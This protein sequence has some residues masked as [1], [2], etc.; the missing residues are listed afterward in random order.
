MEALTF[1]AAHTRRITLGTSV[2]NMPF[3]NPVVLAR[4]LATLD[5]LSGGRSRVGLGQAWSADELE[6]V[7]RRSEGARVAGR[8]V[9]PVLKAMW[10]PDPGG[11]PGPALPRGA[12]DRGAEAGPAAAPAVYLAAYV[13]A[14]APPRGDPG[15]RLAALEPADRG[16]RPRWCRSSTPSRARRA[17][18]RAASRSSTW[19]GAQI[20]SAPL[21]EAKRGL[22]SGSAAQVRADVGPAR[23][24]RRH[25]GDRLERRRDGRGDARRPRALPRSRGLRG[26]HP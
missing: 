2:L 7:G 1:A 6:A 14:G 26:P 8:R 4:R 13:R 5:V 10:G 16:A 12:L 9:H 22:L 20:T 21:D 25:R 3:Y 23:R 11:V 19:R 17:A 24:R 18:T 15:R